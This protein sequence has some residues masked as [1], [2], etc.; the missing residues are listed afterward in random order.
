M[1]LHRRIGEALEAQRRRQPGRARLPL[2]RGPR[3]RGDPLR[4]GRRR[5]GR[6]PRWPRRRRPSTTGAR[7][8]GLADAARARRRRSCAPA[9]P[10][11]ARRSPR[12]R[13][14]PRAGGPRRAGRGRAR[15]LRPPRR[16]GRDRPRG[17][18]AARGGA[19]PAARGAACSRCGCARGWSTRLQFADQDDAPRRA[20][21]RGAG[22]RAP[23]RRP[24]GAA[25]RAR[26]PPRRAAARRPPRRAAAPERG[27]AGARR[28]GS[29]EREL[30]AL[31]HHWRI[32]DLLEAGRIDDARDAQHAALDTLAAELRQPLYHHFARRLG[33][34]VGAD[35]RAASPTPSGSRARPTS[36][37]CAR[38]RATPRRSTPRRLL[39]LRRP[40]GRALGL[41]RHDRRPTSSATPRWSPGARSC[42]WRTC[43]PATRRRAW[44]EF[45]ALAAGR[46]RGD[47]ARHVLVHRDRACSARRA[48]CCATREQAPRP[49]PPARAALASKLV[50]VTPG[51]EPRLAHRFL[52][53]LAAA[54]GA[55]STGAERHFDAALEINARCGLRPVVALMRREFAELLLARDVD[56][57]RIRAG[58]L[59]E[60]DVAR[61]RG[62]RD[63]AAD[64]PGTAT[65]GRTA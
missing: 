13:A 20:Q 12:G 24:A 19:R 32:Y 23:A 17:D 27:A 52:A 41:R 26:E 21:R 10:P 28:R 6:R 14:R 22:D 63:V 2:L 34:R 35:G 18:R 59:L 55:T 57:D 8:A 42:R 60:R 64:Q 16:G 56:G 1:R 47:P 9:T 51:R 44:R 36:S 30:E 33:G 4:A 49:V 43:W 25:G 58:E 37:A 45:R 29:S 15:V 5:A 53:L 61:S 48:R 65:A 39:I 62:R 11:P 31:G 40:R 38:R 46:L 54:L 3:A 50:Q 7:G